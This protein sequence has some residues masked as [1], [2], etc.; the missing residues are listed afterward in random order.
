MYE[1]KGYDSKTICSSISICLQFT[2][3]ISSATARDTVG[4]V[5]KP[6]ASVKTGNIHKNRNSKL[7]ITV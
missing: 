7:K 1:R 4:V 5:F 2:D 3:T 6:T